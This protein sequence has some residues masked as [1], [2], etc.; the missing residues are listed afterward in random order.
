M[1]LAQL[2]VSIA[3]PCARALNAEAGEDFLAMLQHVSALCGDLGRHIGFVV[4]NLDAKMQNPGKRSPAIADGLL[5]DAGAGCLHN[6][7]PL[8]YFALNKCT[9]LVRR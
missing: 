5:V 9:K 8:F 3:P 4:Q 6:G 1:R 2:Y 7:G